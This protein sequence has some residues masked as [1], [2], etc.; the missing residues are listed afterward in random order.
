MYAARGKLKIENWKIGKLS[1]G[2]MGHFRIARE[3]QGIQGMQR[4]VGIDKKAPRRSFCS[5]QFCFCELIN[6][7][8]FVITCVAIGNP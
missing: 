5:N 6:Y 1:F 7:L 8:P 3:M 4:L 2:G